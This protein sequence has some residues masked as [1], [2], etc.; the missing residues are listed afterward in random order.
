MRA[1]AGTLPTSRD[2]D[3]T[4]RADAVA[5]MRPADNEETGSPVRLAP[6]AAM[7]PE[8]AFEDDTQVPARRPKPA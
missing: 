3:W 8:L 6:V 2:S 1:A 5:D 4:R 7:W